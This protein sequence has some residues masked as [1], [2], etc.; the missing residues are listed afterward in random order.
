MSRIGWAGRALPGTELR[1]ADADGR[2]LPLGEVGE[3]LVKGPHV[4][5]GYWRKPEITA[6]T[7]VDGWLRTGDLGLMDEDGFVKIMDRSKD[8]LISGGI[9]VYPAEIE[10]TLA[11]VRS[12]TELAVIG[13]PDKEWGEVPM[14][15]ALCDGDPQQAVRE[16]EAVGLRELASFKRPKHIL[17]RDDPLP[18]TLSGKVSKPE[19]RRAY[20]SVPDAALP[21]FAAKA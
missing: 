4:M 21:L 7:I 10:R 2:T 14:V 3:I 1:I 13:V 8:M 20:S 15:V 9:N 19:L 6:E 11:A 5:Q 16:I 12:V 18:R 17:F